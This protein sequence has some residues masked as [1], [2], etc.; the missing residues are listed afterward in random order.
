MILSF[1]LK[2]GLIILMKLPF[3]L[4]IDWLEYIVFQMGTGGIP[5]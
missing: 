1:G 2:T 5:G 4:N 3:V